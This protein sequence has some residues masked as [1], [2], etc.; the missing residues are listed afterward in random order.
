MPK[1]TRARSISNIQTKSA[2][3][4]GNVVNDNGSS[5]TARG[6]CWSTS[7]NPAISDYHTIKNGTTGI[8]SSNI[9]GLSAGTTYYVK[10]YAT[11]AG[12]TAYGDE[13]TFTTIP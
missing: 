8:F 13:V 11:N 10:A 6:V 9:T 12:G 1:I 4:G 5:I 2:T 7:S 3:G